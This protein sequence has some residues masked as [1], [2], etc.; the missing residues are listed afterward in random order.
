MEIKIDQFRTDT[1]QPVEAPLD[2]AELCAV[3]AAYQAATPTARL[4]RDETDAVEHFDH[5]NPAVAV[6]LAA[7]GRQVAGNG[8][9]GSFH[10]AAAARFNEGSR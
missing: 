4:A 8:V 1:A 7:P 5:A 2:F 10:A 9:L 6:L 3:L